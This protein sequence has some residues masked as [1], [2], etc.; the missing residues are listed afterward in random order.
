MDEKEKVLNKMR[1]LCSRGE[2]CSADIRKRLE[3]YV[4]L[5]AGEI[6]ETL[7]KEQYINDLRYA[8]AF[9]R[10]KSSLLGWGATKIS[11]ALSK[12]GIAQD[13]ISQAIS[14][15]DED[16]SLKR[17]TSLMSTKYRSLKGEK[18]EQMRKL[19]VFR[20]ALGRGYSYE[21]IKR[22]YDTIRPN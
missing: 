3:K 15:I 4:N 13:T 19:K 7:L 21:Q 14:M 2:H 8:T 16:A 11:L 9:A 1:S 5:N 18:E 6:V 20:Y 12:N 10:D 17:L 22:V